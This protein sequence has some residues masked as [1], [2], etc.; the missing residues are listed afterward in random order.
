MKKLLLSLVVISA[1]V[2]SQ[3]A[4]ADNR[5]NRRGY[6]NYGYGGFGYGSRYSSRSPR[7]NPYHYGSY[8]RSSYGRR[9]RSYAGISFGSRRHR[10]SDAGSFFGG[11]FLGSL[12]SYPSY[13]YTPR[14]STTIYRNTPV[15]PQ[16]PVNVTTYSSAPARVAP[17]R[18]LLRDL[19]GNCFEISVDD[20][21]NELREQLEVEACEF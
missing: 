17:G 19:Q 2:I 10:H 20:E 13:D 1:F 4:S 8:N 16:A 7:Y 21:G 11:L 15:G 6:S 9:G 18:R 5:H 12:L 14:R 3:T